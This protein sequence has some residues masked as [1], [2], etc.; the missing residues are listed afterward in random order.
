[1]F[2]ISKP[3]FTYSRSLSTIIIIVTVFLC[4]SLQLHAQPYFPVKVKNRWGLIDSNGV[5][6]MK[7]AY[8]LLYVYG[9][10]NFMTAWLGDSAFLI[11]SRLQIVARTDYDGI[12]EFGEGIFRT[13][14]SRKINIGTPLYGLMDS[15]GKVIIEPKF[16][17]MDRFNDGVAKA[18]IFIDTIGGYRQKNQRA[19]IIDK[20][21]NW[22]IQPK[23]YP[24]WLRSS[25]DSL[26]IFG[27]Y[28]KGWG[29]MDVTGKIIIEPRYCELGPCKN[30]YMVYSLN[31]SS[32]GLMKKDGKITIPEDGKHE[33]SY[34]PQSPD[35]TLVLVRELKFFNNEVL[36]YKYNDGKIYTVNG[37]L[38]YK[39]KYGED[40]TEQNNGSFGICKVKQTEERSTKRDTRSYTIERIWG[41]MNASGKIVVEPRYDFL[42]WS[43][44]DVKRVNRNGKWGFINDDGKEIIP[45]IY[46]DSEPFENGLAAVYVGGAKDY[47]HYA[48]EYP[49]V[50][51]GYVNRKGKI[52][53]KPSR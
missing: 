35:D 19:G 36:A 47:I 12:Y 28:E 33:V 39:A 27:I 22:I 40:C 37:R 16:Y 3:V 18:Y 41:M 38:L 43:E 15:T 53:W 11:N 13:R 1:M 49:N 8:D 25:S 24:N 6:V 46:D 31:Y 52:I 17:T 50:K 9:K 4:A 10:S 34:D 14:L 44:P 42:E 2:L 23:Y 7:P 5:V 48:E 29:A 51:M 45:C 32:S 26:I 20:K 21:G 30:G